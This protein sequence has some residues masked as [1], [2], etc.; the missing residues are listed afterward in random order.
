M[1]R[2][3]SIKR[4]GSPEESIPTIDSPIYLNQIASLPQEDNIHCLSLKQLIGSPQLKQTWQFNFCVD[5]NFILENIHPKV[6]RT[7]DIRI[8]HGYDKKS[9]SLARLTAQ[10]EHCPLQVQLYSV[11]VPMWGTHHS[12]IM[13]NFFEDESCQIVIHTANMV[14]PDWIGMSQAIYKTPLLFPKSGGTTSAPSAPN[15]E[16]GSSRKKTKN[17]VQNGVEVVDVDAETEDES[18]LESEMNQVGQQFQEDFLNYLTNYNH[19]NELIN[20]LK[21]YDFSNVRA[22]FIGSVPGKFM[23]G[24]ESQWGL[25][26][27][28]HL[29]GKVEKKEKGKGEGFFDTDIC[30]SQC[31]SMGSFGPKQDYLEELMEAFHCKRKQ[32]K[33]IFPTVG[34]IQQSMLGWQSGSS[35]HFN[36]LGKTSVEQVE[37]LRQNHNLHKWGSMKAGRERI[38]P[39][40]K[41]YLR[42]SESGDRIRWALV[43]SA[44]LSKPAWGTMEGKGAKSKTARG[45]RIKSY[46]AGVLFFPQLFEN[47]GSTPSPVCSMV[48]TYK[49]NSPKPDIHSTTESHNESK[50]QLQV[51]FRMCWDFPPKEYVSKDEIWSPVVPR[52]D[53]DW[54]GYTWPPTW[55]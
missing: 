17:E 12:K 42:V 22:V 37:D 7:V 31:S 26:R 10:K 29:L 27:L 15:G 40:I 50:S 8:T 11:Y 48:P 46:E 34:Q 55:A 1:S 3:G 6:F 13:V 33:F 2:L 24:K 16:E 39:H 20:K 9:D 23:D 51:G 19:T 5:L 18:P 43:T 45:L 52:K 36:I 4:K 30:V 38:A 49:T 54:L 53:K 35:I 47:A 25:G 41:T 44:N 32:W 28:K 14:E 21:N